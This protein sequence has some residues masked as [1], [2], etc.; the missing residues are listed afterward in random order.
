M[1]VKNVTPFTLGN[2]R[3]STPGVVLTALISALV[4][5]L[6]RT[7]ISVKG[8]FLVTLAFSS[9][10]LAEL[11]PTPKGLSPEFGIDRV[12]DGD[13]VLLDDG[14][15]VRLTGFNS[16]ELKDSG[17]KGRFVSHHGRQLRIG[18]VDCS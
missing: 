7:K 6:F 1:Y 16:F 14:S 10:V 11:C 13:T 8:T 9:V 17:W 15:R 5:A 12:I 4:G 3:F 18:M 2:R